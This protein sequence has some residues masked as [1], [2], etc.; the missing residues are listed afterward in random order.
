MRGPQKKHSYN[1]EFWSKAQ[2]ELWGRRNL[3]QKMYLGSPDDMN[4]DVTSRSKWVGGP[5]WENFG[6]YGQNWF[7]EDHVRYI[8]YWEIALTRFLAK[9]KLF[10]G[11]CPPKA[12]DI[13]QTAPPEKCKALSSLMFRMPRPGPPPS[14]GRSA[15][16]RWEQFNNV[17]RWRVGSGSCDRARTGFQILTAFLLSV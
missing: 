11:A 8:K 4:L 13:F 5:D 1:L 2:T 7:F 9:F 12:K 14:S 17:E 16:G 6:P 10:Q 15:L 3:S